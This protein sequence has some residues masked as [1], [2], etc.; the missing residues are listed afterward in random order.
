M[1]AYVRVG[2]IGTKIISTIKDQDGIAIDISSAT[3]KEF[4]FEKPDGSTTNKAGSFTTDGTDGKLQYVFQSG[5]LNLQGN[6]K[7]IVHIIT[8]TAE[9]HTDMST[10]RVYG[11]EI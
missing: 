10:F 11:V 9:W 8:P 6:W 1:T 4:T 5:D 2:D 7:Y 3:T